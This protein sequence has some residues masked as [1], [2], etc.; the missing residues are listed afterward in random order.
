[1]VR[2]ASLFLL[3]ID[4]FYRPLTE[5]TRSALP[6]TESTQSETLRR[7][8]QQGVRLNVNWV[9]EGIIKLFRHFLEFADIFN[10]SITPSW[11]IQHKV[12]LC[13]FSTDV[14]AH[15][16]LT[17][18]TG[19]ESPC[20]LSHSRMIKIS[21]ISANSRIKSKSLDSLNLWPI[22]YRMGLIHVKNQHQK[23]SYLCRL[24]WTDNLKRWTN[25]LW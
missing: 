18:L 22:G 10:I 21:K 25:N 9:N 24:M 5:P 3:L 11:Y 6:I 15:S 2:F 7:P 8:S 13:I 19:N 20:Q 17:Q 14:A 4:L 23:I 16:G 12:C 1:M